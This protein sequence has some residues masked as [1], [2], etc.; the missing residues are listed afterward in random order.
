MKQPLLN[1]PSTLQRTL[2]GSFKLT[3]PPLT[4]PGPG[5]TGLLG[6]NGAGKS[7]FLRL[8]A[9]AFPEAPRS[10]SLPSSYLGHCQVAWMPSQ[11]TPAFGLSVREILLLGRFQQHQGY[12]NSTD[13][14]IVEEWLE[15]LHL[16]ELADKDFCHLSSGQQRKVSLARTLCAEAPILCLDEPFSHLDPR[17]CLDFA[18]I[19]RQVSAEGRLILLSCHDVNLALN[20]CDSL[21]FFQDGILFSGLVP[22]QEKSAEL[23][24]ALLAKTYQIQYRWLSHNDPKIVTPVDDIP[25]E[26]ETRQF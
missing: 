20:L 3:V 19:L 13:R 26:D 25:G 12:P 7:S 24:L 2:Y 15:K 22:C 5:I 1:I 6:A 21:L 11:L 10:A 14:Q 9:G 16:V 8:L 17:A 23:D 18:A 4:I